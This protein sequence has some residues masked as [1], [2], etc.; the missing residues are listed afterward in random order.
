M[1]LHF[2]VVYIGQIFTVQIYFFYIFMKNH[3]LKKEKKTRYKN[4]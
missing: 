4:F 3:G 1:I 2:W